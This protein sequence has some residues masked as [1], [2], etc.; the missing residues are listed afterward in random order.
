MTITID[1]NTKIISIEQSDL[2]PLGGGIYEL[3][4]DAFRLTLRDL[5]DGEQGIAFLPTHSHNT[6]VILAG[7]TY[8]RF[9]EIINGYTIT[10]ENLQY[11]VNLVDANS[12]VADVTNVNQVSIR[13]ANSA[14]LVTV[15][16]SGISNQDKLDIADQVWNEILADHVGVGSTGEALDNV[17]GGSSPAVIAAAVWDET[18]DGHT[19]LG[20]FG[21]DLVT[22]SDLAASTSTIEVFAGS[23]TVIEGTNTSGSY[24]DTFSRD[25]TYWQITEHAV[26]GLTIEATFNLPNE[27][28]R[29]GSITVFG[30]YEGVPSTTH[31]M[32]C[33]AYNY[34][35][36][37]F[38]ELKEIYMPGGNTTDATH[39][40]EYYER[41]IDRDNN[42]EVKIRLVHHI[43]TYINTHNLYIDLMN[44]SA[45][46]VVTAEAIADAVWDETMGDH[47]AAN[48]TGK[49]LKK[50]L[51]T[52]SFIA[53]K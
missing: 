19:D 23:G 14:G 3:D 41:H 38:E 53:L 50:K 51:A 20:T 22:K 5:E 7:V 35:S 32:E 1:W 49:E 42:N 16:N 47:V 2:T 28:S 9:I 26:D 46:E 45:I 21:G 31:H 27:D 11:A 15:E 24:A 13:S 44:V 39:T 10:F 6:E 30:R 12:N 37:A 4:L 17:S 33:F 29:P 18:S 25:N 8:S 43:T 52:G 40:Q 34:E 36:S 48:S